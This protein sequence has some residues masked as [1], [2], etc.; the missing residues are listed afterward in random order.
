MALSIAHLCCLDPAWLLT[1]ML[2]KMHLLKVN[3]KQLML[4]MEEDGELSIDG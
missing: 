2:V 4:S 1:W 3:G